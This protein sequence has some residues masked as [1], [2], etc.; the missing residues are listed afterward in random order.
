MSARL[1]I[2]WL[3]AV[4][5][6]LLAWTALVLLHTLAGYSDQLRRGGEG[7][8]IGFFSVLASAYLPWVFFTAVLVRILAER[9]D[10]L[11]DSAT[12]LRLLAGSV[13]FFLIPQE[14][15][16]VGLDLA[17][18]GRPASTFWD[19]FAR[20]PAISWLVDGG[21]LVLSFVS[22]YA[23]VVIQENRLAAEARSR[24]QAE[25]LALKLEVEQQRLRALRGQL[26]PHF[27]FNALNAISGLVRAGD[28]AVALSALQQLSALLRYALS[29]SARDWVT[30]GEEIAFVQDYLTL[31]RLRFGE[32][33]RFTLVG[34]DAAAA[35]ADCP[36][37]LLQPLIE[38]AIR[39][40]LEGHDD[41]SDIRLCVQREGERI[42]VEVT[43]SL[44]PDAAPNPG[45]GMGL[46]G[47]RDRLSILYGREAQCLSAS[48]GDQFKVLVSLPVARPE[49]RGEPA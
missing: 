1:R 26:E 15:Y 20:W 46:S 30:L 49:G 11:A 5:G 41:A 36:A 6:S 13:V 25:N 35:A 29:A 16:Q 28:R 37:L 3:Q 14:A 7:T 42:T 31:Q 34:N 48:T 43:N 18:N 22:V 24:S 9:A 32:R 10:R 38:N 17:L 44:H 23:L 21:V 8:F 40:D 19:A 2:S 12:A 47:T 33:L 45:A 27:M 4:G 39:H